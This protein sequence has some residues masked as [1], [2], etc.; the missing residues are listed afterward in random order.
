ML[1]SYLSNIQIS[2]GK[3]YGD[4]VF[5]FMDLLGQGKHYLLKLLL[6]NVA[7]ISSG[8]RE[9]VDSLCR[10]GADARIA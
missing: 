2:L 5:F 4:L 1:F 7:Y 9:S 10:D 8:I 6:Q 3:G